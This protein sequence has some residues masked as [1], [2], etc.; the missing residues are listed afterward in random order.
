[1]AEVSPNTTPA[2]SARD[3]S[4]SWLERLHMD[5]RPGEA[6]LCALLFAIHFL[7]LAFQYT[8]K[9]IRQSV[10]ID[11]LGAEQLPFVYLL[12]A[13]CSYPLI[14][15]YGR[16]M[17]RWS[18][19]R[20]FAMSS[21]LVAASMVGFWWLFSL[22]H[23]WVSLL[24][25]LWIAI[26][27]ILLVSQFWCYA[28]HRLDA[29][30]ARRLFGLV[31]AG[32][33]LGSIGGGQIARLASQNL[34]TFDALGVAAALLVVLAVLI[35]SRAVRATPSK[36]AAGDDANP[37]GTALEN[38]TNAEELKVARDGMNLVR[39]SPYLRSIA[40][41]MLLSAMVAQVIDLQFNWVIEQNT[42][43]LNERTA[44]FGNFY[45]LT[46]VAAFIFQL[47]FTARIHRRLGVGFALRVLPFANGLTTLCFLVAA[48][49][50]PALIL[51]A[52]WLLKIGENGLRYSL[53]Q[54][55]RELL[56]LPVPARDRAK[57]KAFIDVFVQRSAKGLAALALLS[58]TFGWI[59]VPQTVGF[60]LLWLLLW[61][62]LLG[63]TQRRY[64]TAFRQVLRRRDLRPEDAL[65]LQDHATLEALVEGLGS[66]EPRQVL[67]SLELLSVHGRG[68]LVPP[69]ML[70]H[71][72][73][74]VRRRALAILRNEG[75]RDAMA[76]VETLLMDPD[77]G[78]R[79]Q[80][81]RTLA[82]F[83][84]EDIPQLMG[85][86]LNDPDPRMR[87]A[88]LSYLA[89]LDD[90]A[91]R[92]V[93]LS[94][95]AEMIGDGDREVRAEAANALRDMDEPQGQA[96]LVR[97][98]YDRE[99]RVVRRAIEAVLGRVERGASSPL[100]VPILVSSL[101][102]R[103]LKHD[104]RDALVAFGESAIPALQHFM[105]DPQ[106]D[107]WVRRALPKTIARIGGASALQALTES[108]SAPDPF[109]RR[110]V[111][112][113]LG[114]LRQRDP[115]LRAP[116]AAVEVQIGVESRGYLRALIDLESLHSSVNGN[117]FGNGYGNGYGNSYGNSYG[118]GYG[119]GNGKGLD[120]GKGFST[121]NADGRGQRTPHLLERLL[122][123]RMEDYERNL[124][125]LLSLLHPPR[126]IAAAR[127]GLRS[128]KVEVRAHALEYL[129]NLLDGEIRQKVFAVID[130]LPLRERLRRARRFF[131]LDREQQAPTLRR[132]AANR[133][134]GDLD[135]AW[136]NAAAL[137]YIYEHRLVHLYPAIRKARDEDLEPLVQE[138]CQLLIG[139][140]A[141]E[142]RA[143]L[144]K[145]RGGR[146]LGNT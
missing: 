61:M 116:V 137:H 138:T 33:L 55:T 106:E 68:R 10:F 79:V 69:L 85:E 133:P 131:A 113:S 46:G 140:I 63:S 29:R 58:V 15:V 101:R 87:A 119:L 73:A 38:D 25:Y 30:Q 1:M 52:A 88:A 112:E 129:D 90:P 132:L 45:S 3:E 16:M 7:V 23:G 115:L 107:I 144:V 43:T 32:G 65:D 78:V 64:V 94:T 81:T 31:G 145:R 59:T 89:G 4:P 37:A 41:V 49:F 72:D 62:M 102:H 110:K 8:A 18:E 99:P 6:R 77:P 56:F 80:A 57:A 12:A 71:G 36:P 105:N 124:F 21:L 127:G 86:R 121:G 67:Y 126:D 14:Q 104:A 74:E 95:L 82:S 39:S 50:F 130:D 108:L 19:E 93:A 48:F 66:S 98:L 35:S 120:S 100:Y 75:R 123:E 54:A 27:G 139:R 76:L 143:S 117:S 40:A 28:S 92:S 142:G 47:L 22:G 111:I 96:E 44:V 97:L 135:A 91:G 125:N 118:N 2:P 134:E 9:S 122:R 42:S 20:V 114:N 24:F 17:D 34:G 13:L 136:L 26:V 53:D 70:Y 128:G 84:P 11:T 109:L 51:P 60:S 141:E 103:K 5:L 83:A 146:R